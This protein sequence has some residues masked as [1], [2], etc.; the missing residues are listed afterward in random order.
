MG[1]T[2]RT[3]EGDEDEQEGEAEQVTSSRPGIAGGEQR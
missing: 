3:G 1:R 2:W